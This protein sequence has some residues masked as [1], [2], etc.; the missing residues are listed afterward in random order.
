MAFPRAAAGVSRV[1]REDANARSQEPDT[2]FGVIA[3]ETGLQDVRCKYLKVSPHKLHRSG[4]VIGASPQHHPHAAAGVFVFSVFLHGVMLSSPT[5]LKE[6]SEE[7]WEALHPPVLFRYV[8]D[9]V[10]RLWRCWRHAW[11]ALGAIWVREA[12]RNNNLLVA[13]E[14]GL[15]GIES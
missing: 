14:H 3:A 9:I 8:W 11:E 1:P 15:H 5:F 7:V 12:C 6:S 13:V 4:M 10:R 2:H